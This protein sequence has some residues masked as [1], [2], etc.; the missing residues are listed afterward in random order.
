MRLVLRAE[1][2]ERDLE[3]ILENLRDLSREAAVRF[4]TE[5]DSTIKLVA[6]QPGIGKLRDDLIPGL[7]SVTVLKKY[8]VFYLTFDDS[9]RIVRILHGARNLR[10]EFSGD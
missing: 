7:R 8:L 5:I 4:A 2:S 1:E 6:S 10:A 3:G 9:I